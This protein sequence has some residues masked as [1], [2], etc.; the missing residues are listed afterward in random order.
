[1]VDLLPLLERDCSLSRGIS[2]L[3]QTLPAQHLVAAGDAAGK[4]VGDVEEPLLQ[5]VTRF[6]CQQ[7]VRHT[8]TQACTL[9]AN[10]RRIDPYGSMAEQAASN[11]H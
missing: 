8:P 3:Q 10:P 4:V 9:A 2:A 6:E 5:S 7:V 1:M 11:P